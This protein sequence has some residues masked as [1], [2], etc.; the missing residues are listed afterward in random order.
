MGNRVLMKGLVTSPG[1]CTPHIPHIQM[2]TAPSGLQFIACKKGHSGCKLTLI[3]NVQIIEGLRFYFITSI[4]SFLISH[5]R[6]VNVS[7]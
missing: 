6:S 3:L 5:T 7:L 4:F 1:N 2:D